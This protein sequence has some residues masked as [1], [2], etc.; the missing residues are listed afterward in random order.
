VGH[1]VLGLT[2]GRKPKFS[3]SY[4]HFGKDM[5]TAL[6]A[7]AREVRDQAFPDKDHSYHMKTGEL[8][9]LRGLLG[10]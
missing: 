10:S 7:Y 1:D 5:I 8:E 4:A 6:D 2:Q 3:K 9:R